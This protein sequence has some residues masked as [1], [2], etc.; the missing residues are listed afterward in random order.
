MWIEVFFT[1]GFEQTI[2]RAV[3]LACA[4]Y[5]KDVFLEPFPF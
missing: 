5:F 2:S 1:D 3:I 4:Y